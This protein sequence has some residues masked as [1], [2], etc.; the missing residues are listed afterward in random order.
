[1]SRITKI[2]AS[3]AL[4]LFV[5]LACP[6]GAAAG[7]HQVWDEAHFFKLQT[8]EDVDQTLDD[9]RTRFGKDL[10]IETFASIP[11]DFKQQYQTD[12]KEKFF[13][14]W[15]VT[16]AR[17]LEVNGV[18]ILITGEPSHLQVEVGVETRKKAFT[19][20]DR[21][22]LVEQLVAAFKQ[23]EFDRGIFQAAQFVHDRMARN[24]GV[25]PG[26]TTRPATRPAGAATSADTVHGEDA[27]APPQAGLPK[28]PDSPPPSS[29]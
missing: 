6:H 10:M 20:A 13:E 4:S 24:M 28:A 26:P 2:V 16:E 7:M 12:G 29:K 14:G 19:L 17:G 9:I 5:L 11:D 3:I 18:I 21:D 23:K 27:I 15:T 22:E 8:V 25:A 1:V